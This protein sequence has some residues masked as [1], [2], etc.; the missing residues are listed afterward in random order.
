MTNG[1]ESRVRARDGYQC[2][3]CALPVMLG[4][5]YRLYPTRAEL[6]DE[7]RAAFLLCPSCYRHLDGQIP[8]YD[9]RIIGSGYFMV[10]RHEY[11]DASQS[12]MFELVR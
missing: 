12:L 9:W 6:A 10:G 7:E 4:E 5:V 1:L 2:R 8:G 11:I 3:W